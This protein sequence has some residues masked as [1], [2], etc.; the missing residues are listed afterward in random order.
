MFHAF[1]GTCGLPPYIDSVYEFVLW[2]SILPYFYMLEY[3][4][5]FS[6]KITCIG[7]NLSNFADL[8]IQFNNVNG[9]TAFV[10]VS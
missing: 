10:T 3:S 5:K 7:I 9:L 8:V 4:A 2:E 6:I 1:Q